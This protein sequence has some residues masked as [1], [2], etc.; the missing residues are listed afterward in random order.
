M[1]LHN[2][3]DVSIVL[4]TVTSDA[5]GRRRRGAAGWWREMWTRGRA[6]SGENIKGR[7]SELRL[8]RSLCHNT[9]I[10][11]NHKWHRNRGEHPVN[12]GGRCTFCLPKL[13]TSPTWS[14]WSLTNMSYYLLLAYESHRETFDLCPLPAV[15]SAGMKCHRPSVK[16][17]VFSLLQCR[18][19]YLPHS[20]NTQLLSK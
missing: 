11:L 15:V 1:E 19:K 4:P 5:D 7:K 8:V 18:K 3:C 10:T 16:Y 14:Q 20:R 12:T 2:E 13:H 6:E 17:T 9:V